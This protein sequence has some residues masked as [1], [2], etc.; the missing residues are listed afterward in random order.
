MSSYELSELSQKHSR[1]RQELLAAQELA[2]TNL[3]TKTRKL[4]QEINNLPISLASRT[5]KV[6]LEK[7]YL[8][9]DSLEQKHANDLLQLEKTQSEGKRQQALEQTPGHQAFTQEL[10][11]VKPMILELLEEAATLKKLQG[12]KRY[13]ENNVVVRE[14]E[15]ET[16][17]WIFKKKEK[18]HTYSAKFEISGELPQKKREKACK[19][20]Y[21]ITYDGTGFDVEAKSDAN[22]SQVI[23]QPSDMNGVKKH[24]YGTSRSTLV[25]ALFSVIS[26]VKEVPCACACACYRPSANAHP[27]G[28]CQLPS[29]WD[30]SSTGKLSELQKKETEI[31]LGQPSKYLQTIHT[32]T[33]NVVMIYHSLLGNLRYADADILKFFSLVEKGYSFQDIYPHFLDFELKKEIEQL[34]KLGFLVLGDEEKQLSW[35]IEQREL[36]YNRGE[37]VRWLRL[38]TD[39]GCNIACTYCHGTNEIRIDRDSQRM[40]LDVAIRAIQLYANLLLEHKQTNLM[41]IRYFGGEP[42]LN[43]NVVRDS[44][45][46]ATKLAKQYGLSLDILLN[47]NGILLSR[48]IVK[49]LIRYRD[50]LHVIVSLDGAKDAHNAVRVFSNGS[51]SFDVVNR[52]LDLL[53]EAQIPIAISATLGEHNKN[54]LPELIDL[55]LKRGIHSMGIDPIRIVSKDGDPVALADALIDAIEYGRSRDFKI[56]GLWKEVCERL[57]HENRV[58]GTFCGGSGTELSVLPNGEIYPCQSQPIWLGTLDDVESRELFKTDAYHHVTM[59]VV[60]NLPECR[61]C[62]IEGLCAGGCAADAYAIGNDLYGRTQHCEFLRKMVQYHLTIT[63]DCDSLTEGCRT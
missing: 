9:M 6:E 25:D 63:A 59:R 11:T 19:V 42:L 27:Y 61:G 37:M 21:S 54:H 46:Y 3:K 24:T 28:V 33:S 36:S 4:Q 44:L 62:E 18:Y 22:S 55:L 43:W 56:G 39:I 53:Q 45:D 14:Q 35:K 30:T 34:K 48:A 32:K 23:T 29:L 8:E 40:S 17:V 38:N 60:G 51:G 16:G 52:G 10:L 5:K 2:E 31:P 58:M 15:R 50:N 20:I 26:E 41:Q 13:Y 49:E 12:I 1:E 57:E 7:L 47:T